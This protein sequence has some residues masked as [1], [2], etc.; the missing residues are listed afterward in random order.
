MKKQTS[1]LFI[2]IFILSLLFN[3]NFVNAQE[4]IN[5]NFDPNR[6]IDDRVFTDTSTFS[7]ASK[8][9]SFLEDKGSP[10]ANTDP[11]FVALLKEPTSTLM[12]QTL[13]DPNPDSSKPRTAAQIIFDAAKSSGL[14]PQVI[15]VTLNKEQSLI[16]GRQNSTPE[17]MQRALDFAM[18]FGCPD[19]QPCGSIYQGFYAQLFGGFDAEN[20]KY[21][22]AAKSLM[23]SYSTP[24]GRG[25]FIN[26]SLSKVGDTITLPNTLGG[27]EGVQANQTITLGNAATAALYRYTPHV[28][29]GNYNFWRFFN[30]WFG[31]STSGD[32]P[33]K[34]D[35]SSS[36]ASGLVKSS[37]EPGAYFIEGN[38]RYRI[39]SFVARAYGY[40]LSRA[41]NISDSTMYKYPLAGYYAVP[42]DTFVE[43]DG[44]YY[45]FTNNQKQLLSKEQIAS[46]GLKTNRADSAT[47]S[48]VSKYPDFGTPPITENP[49]INPNIPSTPTPT[50][51]P[52]ATNPG[53]LAEGSIVKTAS[54]Q[55][56][57]LVTNGKIK[58]FTYA[59]FLQ[60]NALANMKVV[61]DAELAPYAKDGLVLPKNQS[62]VKSATSNTVYFYED[63][64]KK[65]MDGEIFRNRGFSFTN[66]YVLTDAEINPLP[67]GNFPDPVDNTYFKAKDN[68][69][70]YLF[71]GGKKISISAFVAKQRK[72]TPDFTFGEDHIKTMAAGTPMAPKDGTIIKGDKKA[73]VFV[74]TGGVA[75]PMTYD[76]FKAR[77]ITPAQV[78]TL[79]QAEVDGYA[80]G[81]L[82][83][84]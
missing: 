51:P 39:F 33:S 47:E 28:F 54:S 14:N 31:K 32:S 12:K 26:G 8:I 11:S 10:L 30:S 27:Y 77:S 18:G 61:T 15:L 45:F 25:P 5:S 24:G 83:T 65:P 35:T 41:K 21:L 58:L 1:I 7:S 80:K 59:T 69:A 17:Q 63:G 52:P 50:T 64:K 55:A 67:L 57:Y 48:E 9:Q 81:S 60:Y 34:P 16:T 68:G 70:L 6:L 19:S 37:S 84:K 75:F 53:K 66:V 4:S 43:A 22:G 44:K 78:N 76:A 46:K 13:E 74:V 42:D 23:K 38:Y 56:V 73:D 40:S 36:S 62:L 2:P 29:N 71:K 20:N 49:I 79:P 82:L 3:S 72:I